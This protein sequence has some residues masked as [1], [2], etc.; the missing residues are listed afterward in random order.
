MIIK[1]FSQILSIENIQ[2]HSELFKLPKTLS[3]EKKKNIYLLANVIM[4]S[5]NKILLK[6][7]YKL[8]QDIIDQE[9]YKKKKDM[10]NLW[11]RFMS[12]LSRCKEIYEKKKL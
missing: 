1:I 8:L 2:S 4:E 9:N 6:K 5:K 3:K 7:L 11:E 10:V 12:F